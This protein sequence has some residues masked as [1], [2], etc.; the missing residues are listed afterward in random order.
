MKVRIMNTQR[1][2]AFSPVRTTCLL[3]IAC[4]LLTAGSLRAQEPEAG[5]LRGTPQPDQAQSPEAPFRG[6]MLRN[7]H[8]A[9]LAL[10][11]PQIE[12]QLRAERIHQLQKQMDAI[13][14]VEQQIHGAVQ[15]GQ[16]EKVR[17][18]KHHLAELHRDLEAWRG[19]HGSG[20][21]HDVSPP[22]PDEH[23][24]LRVLQECSERLRR[25]GMPDLANHLQEHARRMKQE[26]LERAEQAERERQELDRRR[27]QASAQSDEERA[28]RESGADRKA[29]LHEVELRQRKLAEH[30]EQLTISVKRM[31]EQLEQL[32]HKVRETHGRD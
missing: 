26:L 16:D 31:Q 32:Q 9:G 14:H 7:P 10:W 30:V 6:G 12:G 5:I 3:P 17:D 27:R 22:G 28:S 18:L 13:H 1:A 19:E 23:H 2:A 11:S 15:Q 20:D 21:P 4:V 24:R 25:E 8:R 29:M